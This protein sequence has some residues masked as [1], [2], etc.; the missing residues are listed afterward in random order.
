MKKA[1]TSSAAIPSAQR[2]RVGD[3]V[4]TPRV[5]LT[6]DAA[7]FPGGRV[8]HL[9]RLPVPF[10]DCHA[11]SPYDGMMEPD[12]ESLFGRPT[13]QGGGGA[14]LIREDAR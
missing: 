8:R 1:T 9:R 14:R 2:T 4:G 11:H 13:P 3:P 6:G 10:H 5:R 7:G 12:I